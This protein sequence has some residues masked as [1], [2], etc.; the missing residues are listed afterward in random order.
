[1]NMKHDQHKEMKKIHTLLTCTAPYLLEVGA[2]LNFP[3]LYKF[4][5]CLL[6]KF[7][8]AL[9]KHIENAREYGVWVLILLVFLRF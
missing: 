4:Y 6:Y 7:I 3:R 2:S 8:T 1:M 5:Y 9:R